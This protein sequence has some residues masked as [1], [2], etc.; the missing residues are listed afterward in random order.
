MHIYQQKISVI[1]IYSSS[2]I[3]VYCNG[4]NTPFVKVSFKTMHYFW[5][6]GI[7]VNR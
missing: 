2:D 3:L 5:A 7:D 6:I 1:I 4:V